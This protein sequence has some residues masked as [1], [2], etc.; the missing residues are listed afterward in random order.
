L[1][2]FTEK[3]GN[4]QQSKGLYHNGSISQ[5]FDRKLPPN[6]YFNKVIS[7]I[8]GG[9]IMS[10]PMLGKVWDIPGL[11]TVY[12]VTMMFHLI[13]DSSLTNNQL[14]KKMR[15]TSRTVIRTGHI[16]VSKG[17]LSNNKKCIK[18]PNDYSVN[19]TILEDEWKLRS[20]QQCHNVTLETKLDD[21]QQCHKVT[22]NSDTESLKQCHKVTPLIVNILNNNLTR[23]LSS[24]SVELVEIKKEEIMKEE[25]KSPEQQTREWVAKR[26]KHLR[27][28]GKMA[29]NIAQHK[30]DDKLTEEAMYHITH[31]DLASFPT[32]N[33]AAKGFLTLV[34]EGRWRT[35]DAMY[36]T[37]AAK[38]KEPRPYDKPVREESIVDLELVRTAEQKANAA[39]WLEQMIKRPYS[40]KVIEETQ[41]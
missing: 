39:I 31:R 33:S 13:Y 2:I 8:F 9:E 37:D 41:H 16:L 36:V 5:Q 6:V 17:Y 28:T 34:E 23:D 18:A 12:E 14:S 27:D 29:A 21:I 30:S 24:S 22:P 35:P 11:E 38:I 26:V 7:Q 20:S 1:S 4:R 25:I 40:G 10:N 19:F 3:L 32:I 15:C